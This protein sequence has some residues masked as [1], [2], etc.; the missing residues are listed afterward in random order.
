[1]VWIT[2][3]RTVSSKATADGARSA[4]IDDGP[5]RDAAHPTGSEKCTGMFVGPGAD[6]VVLGAHY[7]SCPEGMVITPE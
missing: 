5:R 2:P 4:A 6:A 7:G 3:L 1:M